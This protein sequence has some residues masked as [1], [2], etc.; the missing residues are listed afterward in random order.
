MIELFELVFK[1]LYFVLLFFY[2]QYYKHQ[3]LFYVN[4]YR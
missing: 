1:E 3:P 2:L 4:I